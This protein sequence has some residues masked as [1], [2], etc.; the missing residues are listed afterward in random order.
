MF[1]TR[2][3]FLSDYGRLD[4]R[5]RYPEVSL[6][7][8]LAM[9]KLDTPLAS[10]GR[11]HP[12]PCAPPTPTSLG[13]Q[14]KCCQ[15]ILLYFDDPSQW[16]AVYKAGDKVKSVRRGWRWG[17]GNKVEAGQGVTT[18]LPPPG[19]PGQGVSDQAR[20]QP[21]HQPHHPVCLVRLSGMGPA[22][23]QVLKVQP[24][25]NAGRLQPSCFSP[26]GVR[27]GNSLPELL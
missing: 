11:G 4:F 20:E 26:G 10:Q 25:R 15:N 18:S 13:L 12:A 1:L 23:G 9:L 5:F 8:T 3:C 7:Q 19:L 24:G 6:P 17:W 14:A 16:P 21:G 27:G 22:S 2:F